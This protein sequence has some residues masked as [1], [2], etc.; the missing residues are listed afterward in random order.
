MSVTPA[1]LLTVAEF[2]RLPDPP[3]GARQELR[4]GELVE[5][6]PPKFLH[7]KIQW[8]LT[9]ALRVI[10]GS[11]WIVDKE[12]PFRPRPEYEVRIA[13]VAL[14]SVERWSSAPDEGYLP[15]TPEIVAEVL[16]PSNSASELNLRQK[17]CLDN[18]ARE[19]WII[20]PD[21]RE[22]QISTPDRLARTY[23]QGETIQIDLLG[24]AL[25]VDDI[26]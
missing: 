21:L 10:A 9:N 12:L 4:Q 16:S 23:R 13:D 20:D 17:I 15:G 3:N 18:G 8:R 24:A 5:M 26:V 1:G 19:F 6:P 25:H 22:I 7:S 14:L 11:N 2:E